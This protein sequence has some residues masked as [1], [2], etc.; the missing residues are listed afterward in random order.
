MI[1]DSLQY[2]VSGLLRTNPFGQLLICACNLICHGLYLQQVFDH[3][4]YFFI[5]VRLSLEDPLVVTIL[6]KVYYLNQNTTLDF[7]S[8]RPF[9]VLLLKLVLNYKW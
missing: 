2:A 3:Q 7:S 1:V 8:H 4:L 5:S 9:F 6:G